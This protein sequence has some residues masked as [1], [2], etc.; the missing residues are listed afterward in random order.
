M[1]NFTSSATTFLH[2]HAPSDARREAW[3]AFVEGGLPETSDEVWRYAPLKDFSLDRFAVPETPGMTE[4]STLATSLSALSARVVRV[5]DGFLVDAGAPLDGVEVTSDDSADSLAG[6]SL[7]EHYQRD[8]F[9]LLNCALAPTGVSIRVDA[10]VHVAAP[11]LVVHSA[12]SGASFPRTQIVLGRGAQAT[13]IE[14]FEG[15]RDGLV[16]PLEEYQLNDNASLQ[17]VNYQRL[18]DTAW[19]VSRTTGFL[20]RDSRLVQGVVGFGAHYD[21]SRNDAELRGANSSNELRTTFLGSGDQ[22]HDFRTHQLHVAPRTTSTLLSKG[23]VADS[24]RSVYT[25]LIE[26]EKGAKRTDARQT[27]HNL[28]LSP[29]AH[30]DSVPNLDIRENDVM[31]AHA[32]SVG[33]LDELQRWYLESRGV[34]RG[35]AERLLIQGFFYEM[36]SALPS[37]LAAVVEADVTET[38]SRVAV[39]AP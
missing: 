26:I 27:N 23:A 14:L 30:A 17:L 5:V 22:V 19:H 21:R 38:L 7:L 28:L 10:G 29:A 18:D 12:T 6:A 20:A 11:I 39:V 2:E 36:L 31:C 8:S 37:D 1:K 25:G 3:T 15:G 24:S 32:S 35:D 16:V 33:P 4:W 13:I 9:S 34:R